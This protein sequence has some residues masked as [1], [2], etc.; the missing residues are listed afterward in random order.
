MAELSEINY[1]AF[2]EE[3]NFLHAYVSE[4]DFDED[5]LKNILHSGTVYEKHVIEEQNW[6]Q[7]WESQLQPVI[8]AGFVGIRPSFHDRI[9]NV[10]HDLVIT[11]KMSFGTGH[12]D[13]TVLMIEMMESINFRDKMVVDFGTGTGVLAILSEKCG[14]SQVTAID[15]DDWSIANTRENVATNNCLRVNLKQQSDLSG[16][17]PADIFLANINLN[18]LKNN[19]A[20]ISLILKKGSFLLVSGFLA[21]D[22]REMQNTFEEMSFVNFKSRHRGDWVAILFEKR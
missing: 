18:V 15:M 20:A 9:E 14:A 11:P 6:N 1:Y 16:I 19:A 22:E 5:K 3:N 13:T 7:Q 12:H 10:K 21:G 17:E 4:K 2:E 8:V